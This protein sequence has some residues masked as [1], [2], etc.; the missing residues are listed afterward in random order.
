[1]RVQVSPDGTVTAQVRPQRSAR[2]ALKHPRLMPY[3]RLIAGVLLIN[4]AL[5]AYHLGDWRIDDGSALAGMAPLMLVN[6]AAAVLIRQQTVLNVLFGL[7]GRGSRT[8]PLWLR[9]SV[10]KVHHV[11]G[12]H[13]GA[14]LAG[15][16]WLCAFATV[17]TIAPTDPPTLVLAWSVVVLARSSASARPRPC[18]PVPTTS[19]RTRTA[20]RAGRRSPSSGR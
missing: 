6:V 16:A 13:A 2:R 1:M 11:G 4:A 15:T 5:L 17:A 20:S 19:S 7:A 10:S 18:A 8:W 9:W 12:I 14:A 3:H